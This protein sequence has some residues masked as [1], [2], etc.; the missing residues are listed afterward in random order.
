MQILEY[1]DAD[2]DSP[3]RAWFESLHAQAAAKVTVALTRIELGNF[4]N[5]KSVGARVREFRIDFGPGYRV[6]FAKD[7]DG[8]VILLAGGTKSRQQK[9]IATAQER[10]ADY[11]RRK[12]AER[13]TQ[14]RGGSRYSE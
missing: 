14:A 3:Y 7:G 5:V 12:K 1:L 10:W 6:Y 8:L 11:N 4:S 9:D 13:A 2:G